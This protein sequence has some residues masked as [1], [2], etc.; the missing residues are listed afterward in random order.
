MPS[1]TSNRSRPARS[2]A[3]GRSGLASLL[4]ALL[5]GCVPLLACTAHAAGHAE[6]ARDAAPVA[7]TDAPARL[8]FYGTWSIGQK[9]GDGKVPLPT[10]L[11]ELKD[12]GANMVVGIGEDT[13]VLRLLPDGMLAVP[14]CSLMKKRDWQRN[15]EWDEGQARERLARIGARFAHDPKVYGVCITH[16]V[17][18]YADHARRRWMY[19]LAKS[20]MGD[21]KVI[22]Y[23]GRL[24]DK[25]NPRG[26]KV[27]G[28]GENGERETDVLF[29][30]LPAVGQ[31]RF[32][33]DNVKHLEDA[34]EAAAKTPGVPVWGQT[35]INAD[36][37]MVTG[38]ETMLSVWGAHGENMTVWADA[39]AA[40]TRDD[41]NGHALR[42]SAFFWRS[43]GRFPWDL[44]YPA[45]S[46]HRARMRA[47]GT[48]LRAAS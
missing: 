14:G 36:N 33:R 45:F 47:V 25:E 46:D 48:K 41:G 27:W 10:R 17:T 9:A 6:R 7:K 11:L 29:V 44:G 2:F 43:L 4:G 3:C 15:G 23:Y 40:T 20:Y 24:W 5:I 16:E 22:Q 37:K 34:L 31:K 1:D 21:K 12:L 28:Y 39:L 35:S 8:Q 26:E 13:D 42:L 38:P 18:E 30:S 19:Q 32:Q